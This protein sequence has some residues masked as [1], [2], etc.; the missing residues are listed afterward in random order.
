MKRTRFPLL[1]AVAFAVLL[2]ALSPADTVVE[3]IVAR[4]NNEIVTRS[5]YI[6]SRDQLKQEVQ[7]QDPNNAD[8]AFSEGRKT[9]CAI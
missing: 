6:R 8:K 9:F 1:L 7:Q 4:V 2:P 3:E 5:E